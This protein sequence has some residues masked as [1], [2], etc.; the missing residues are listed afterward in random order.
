MTVTAADYNNS[1]EGIVIQT[2]DT[3]VDRR[4]TPFWVRSGAGNAVFV[5]PSYVSKLRYRFSWTQQSHS[6]LL[7]LSISTFLVINQT[8]GPEGWYEG[9]HVPLGNRVVEIVA[10]SAMNWTFSQTQ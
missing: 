7:T 5:I 1:S 2:T 10:S 9:T 8:L 4:L 3:R 6:P